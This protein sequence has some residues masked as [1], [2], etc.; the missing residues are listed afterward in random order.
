VTSLKILLHDVFL[1]SPA[2]HIATADISCLKTL[3]SKLYE[4]GVAELSLIIHFLAKIFAA[5]NSE[6]L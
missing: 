1:S 3:L 6:I 4:F 2:N 5:S